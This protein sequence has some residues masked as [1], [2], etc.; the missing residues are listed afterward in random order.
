MAL[1]QLVQG[2]KGNE[3]NA[4]AQLVNRGFLTEKSEFQQVH[5]IGAHLALPSCMFTPPLSHSLLSLFA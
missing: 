4:L 1:R 2:D 3:S 5:R